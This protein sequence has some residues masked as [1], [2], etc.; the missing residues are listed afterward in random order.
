MKAIEKIK[1]IKG[2]EDWSVS[3][4]SNHKGLRVIESPNGSQMHDVQ[5]VKQVGYEKKGLQSIDIDSGSYA[6]KLPM[7]H[8]ELHLYLNDLEFNNEWDAFIGS[9]A[10][11]VMKPFEVREKFGNGF[12]KKMVEKEVV[13]S[14]YWYGRV[15]IEDIRDSEDGEV[16]ILIKEV[17]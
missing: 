5:V 1:D 16:L 10:V 14:G 3:G 7:D 12:S 9:D 11:P 15:K 2:F 4:A 8:P 6:V 17:A 13:G